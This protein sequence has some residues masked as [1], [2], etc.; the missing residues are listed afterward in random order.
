[1]CFGFCYGW[2]PRGLFTGWALRLSSH[3]TDCSAKRLLRA[4]AQSL[5]GLERGKG[6]VN[7]R[8]NQRAWKSVILQQ[9]SL[10]DRE[11]LHLSLRGKETR[12]RMDIAV[13]RDAVFLCLHEWWRL[14]RFQRGFIWFKN[15]RKQPIST[16][17]STGENLFFTSLYIYVVFEMYV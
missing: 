15:Y 7:D 12:Q 11:S 17:I 2:C 1:M 14:L 6:R 5:E 4:S 16:W 13:L 8:E 10:D 9:D 3:K